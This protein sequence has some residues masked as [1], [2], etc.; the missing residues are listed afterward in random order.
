MSVE[1]YSIP[2]KIAQPAQL[3]ESHPTPPTP[4]EISRLPHL[5]STA[6]LVFMHLY[7]LHT[8]NIRATGS[9]FFRVSRANL[10]DRI[11]RS[12]DTVKRCIKELRGNPDENGIPEHD[13]LIVVIRTQGC[14]VYRLL[15]RL[16]NRVDQSFGKPNREGKTSPR[17][18]EKEV[19]NNY[20]LNPHDPGFK[21]LQTQEG[22]QLIARLILLNFDWIVDKN[23]ELSPSHR[24]NRQRKNRR[25][26]ANFVAQYGLKALEY[27][28]QRCESTSLLNGAAVLHSMI[29]GKL[30][31]SEHE[32]FL[33]M[34]NVA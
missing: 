6:K 19:P 29:T 24:E 21:L 14:N 27:V 33:R 9:A 31:K 26:V 11:N 7:M 22:Q 1:K 17:I 30:F 10:G 20:A 12:V 25:D 5:S 23:P 32:K 15:P 34:R 16:K 13:P 2:P 8:R 4:A 28:I 3:S 18:R